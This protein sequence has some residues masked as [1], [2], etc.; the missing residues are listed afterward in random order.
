MTAHATNATRTEASWD[1]AMIASLRAL[2]TEGHSA[3]E[4][5][6]RLGISKNAVVGKVHRLD[7]PPRPSPIRATS[8]NAAGWSAT[9]KSTAAVPLAPEKS[10]RLVKQAEPAARIGV[11]L[12]SP[13]PAPLPKSS[14]HCC[15][16]LGEPG[17]PGFRFCETA[18]LPGRPYCPEHCATA[19]VPRLAKQR[20]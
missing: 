15:W 18:I 11:T 20:D 6:R 2:W 8:P 16:P 9:P 4:I 17:R 12:P 5:G 19:Y 7:L 1:E 14:I 10:I 3:A 13:K